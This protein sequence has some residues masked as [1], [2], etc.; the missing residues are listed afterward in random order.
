MKSVWQFS[1]EFLNN[2]REFSRN[3]TSRSRFWGIFNSLFTLDLDFETFSFH[4]SLSISISR[5]FHFTFH[6][7]NGW[8]RFSFH[9]SLLELPIPTL[10][11]HWAEPPIWVR[12]SL[13]SELQSK[14]KRYLACLSLY[15]I[16]LVWFGGL[17]STGSSQQAQSELPHWCWIVSTCPPLQRE[18][19]CS[20]DNSTI[21]PYRLLRNGS[22]Y[23]VS[24]IA[25]L[26]QTSKKFWSK[27][28]LFPTV[29]ELEE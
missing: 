5:Y 4:F 1:P 11:G 21:G 20:D 8:T 12:R 18:R 9:F 29:S 13:K 17:V 10:A 2:S 24:C 26:C 28:F 7:R 6:S 22:L 19:K 16:G 14:W 25:H 3:F 15:E 27:L 23:H